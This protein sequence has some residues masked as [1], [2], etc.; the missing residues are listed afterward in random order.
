MKAAQL[1]VLLVLAFSLVVT[2]GSFAQNACAK[3]MADTA[4]GLGSKV[5]K[6]AVLGAIGGGVVG[7][8]VP[9]AVCG[10]VIGALSALGDNVLDEFKNCGQICKNQGVQSG[11]AGASKCDDVHN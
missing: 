6:D 3:C 11:D 7:G 10:A 4:N 5:A 9:G 2:D 8:G 1:L